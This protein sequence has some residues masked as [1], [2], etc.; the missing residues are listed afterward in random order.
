STLRIGSGDLKISQFQLV[1]ADA[2]RGI[3]I[4]GTGSVAT[5]GDFHA[6]TPVV[7]GAQGVKNSI[8]AVGDVTFD[9]TA[10]GSGRATKGLGAT[11]TVTGSS[12]VANSDFIF[13]SG[14]L[15]L[16]AN[17][18]APADGVT[19]GG[20]IDTS[21]T[22]QEFNDVTRYTSGGEIRLLSASGDVTID[23]N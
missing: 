14:S 22:S 17:G 23:A 1:D 11:L 15:T 4:A 2:S 21:G 19:V 3:F 20:R 13:H 16:Q 9:A 12:V 5:K 18:A 6:A 8:T 10:G 7:T